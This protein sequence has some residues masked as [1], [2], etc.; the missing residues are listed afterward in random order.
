MKA[1]NVI[2]VS[3]IILLLSSGWGLKAQSGI[4]SQGNAPLQSR[5]SPRF[6]LELGASVM[7]GFGS[8]SIFSQSV[9]PHFL[10]NPSQRLNLVVGSVFSGGQMSGHL[11]MPIFKEGLAFGQFTTSPQNIF[12][13]TFYAVG[14]YQVNERLTIS[15]AGWVERN[16]VQMFQPQMNPQA[17]NLNPRGAMVGFDYRISPSFSFGAQI[18]VRQGFN[19]LN[20][21]LMPSGL[22]GG[23][24]PWLPV[25]PGLHW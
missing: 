15:G 17:F 19:S 12:S 1:K 4:F 21:F 2:K 3:L 20:P 16:N 23:F 18:S 10:F 8:G 13:A 9:A 25:P 5:W 22:Q 14:T 11:G 6:G 24:S 7:T